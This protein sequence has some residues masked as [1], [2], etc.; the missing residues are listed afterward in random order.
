MHTHA[1][2]FRLAGSVVLMFVFEV[3]HV[4]LRSVAQYAR[5]LNSQYFFLFQ[6]AAF[7]TCLIKHLQ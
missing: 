1:L 6:T 7:S 5:M 3:K 4:S 2:M